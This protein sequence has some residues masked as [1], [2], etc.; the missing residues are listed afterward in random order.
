VAHLFAFLL[1][2]M[3]GLFLLSFAIPLL[4]PGL[5]RWLIIN[6]NQNMPKEDR[7]DIKARDYSKGSFGCFTLLYPGQVK[8]IE[9]GGKF[10]R[11]IMAYSHHMFLGEQDNPLT[12]LNPEYWEVVTTPGGYSDSHPI[13]F[14]AQ[15]T[16]LGELVWLLY[17]PVS[18]AWWLWKRW[19]YFLTGAVFVGIA[20]QGLKIYPMERFRRLTTSDGTIQLIRKEDYSDHYRVA[21]FQYPAKIASADSQDK[22]PFDI[23]LNEIAQVFNPYLVSYNTDDDWATRFLGSVSN[24]VTMFTRTH[25]ANEVW[26]A[27]STDKADELAKFVTEGGRHG[28]DSTKEGSTCE[29]GIKILESQVL[30]ISPTRPEDEKILGA[31]A[32]ADVQLKADKKL[33][34]GRAAYIRAEGAAF[35]E[36]PKSEI[37]IQADAMVRAAEAAGKNG[38]VI[39]GGSSIDPI[40]AAILQQLKKNGAPA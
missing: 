7:E 6:P 8:I 29:F 30:N 16:V 4:I 3:I 11:C 25:P 13:P 19:V 26:T 18:I 23:V 21:H 33:A 32:R 28:T 9:R 39:L 10:I 22:I 20:F 14:P 36:F 27:L 12:W 1:G 40:Q 15:K 2:L 34:E 31:E 24:R 5:I 17:S 37:I 38:T 35:A